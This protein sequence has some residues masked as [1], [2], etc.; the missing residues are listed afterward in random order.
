MSGR[1]GRPKGRKKSYRSREAALAAA[2]AAAGVRRDSEIERGSVQV[3][4]GPFGEF[5]GRS[6]DS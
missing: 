4:E 5:T 2:A 1:G 3:G 6:G